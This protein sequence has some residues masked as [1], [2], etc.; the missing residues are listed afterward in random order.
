M[1]VEKKFRCNFCGGLIC[2]EQPGYGLEWDG[3]SLEEVA[4]STAEEHLCR[5]CM[6]AL[7]AR[8]DVILRR[9]NNSEWGEG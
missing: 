5:G 7:H 3:A 4:L 8:A 1:S 9:E 6:I 2:Q